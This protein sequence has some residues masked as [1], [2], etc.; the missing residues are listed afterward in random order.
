M[1][2]VLYT[3]SVPAE[4]AEAFRSVWRKTTRNIHQ[5]V[6]GALGS[7]CLAGIDDPDE[8]VTVALWESEEQWKSFIQTAKTDSM[9][10]LHELAEQISVKAYTQVGDETVYAWLSDT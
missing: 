7:F 3:W 4:R 1:I 5:A 6:D 8:V 10:S 9:K 2:R